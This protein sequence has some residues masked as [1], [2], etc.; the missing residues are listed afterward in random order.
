MTNETSGSPNPAPEHA[1]AQDQAAQI[2]ELRLQVRT[3][4]HIVR[5][6]VE[7]SPGSISG[8]HLAQFRRLLPK[9]EGEKLTLADLWK[10]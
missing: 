7:V 5:A 2:A 1:N 9:I 3:L 10:D 4:A 6:L 8:I